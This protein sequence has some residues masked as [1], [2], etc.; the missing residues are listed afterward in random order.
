MSVESIA[1]ESYEEKS[2][3]DTY[4]NRI[5]KI[6]LI[7]AATE[8]EFAKDIEAGFYAQ[9]LLEQEEVDTTRDLDDL[10]TLCREGDEAKKRLVEA[11]LRL[12]IPIAHR[13]RGR[14]VP[15]M[16]L[17]QEGSLALLDAAQKFD[18]A[19]GFKFSTFAV[20]KIYE[21]IIL[22]FFTQ[23]R[24]DAVNRKTGEQLSKLSNTK[25]RLQET[26]GRDATKQELAVEMKM[27]EEQVAKL[28]MINNYTVSLD[29]TVGEDDTETL[30]SMIEDGE[31]SGDPLNAL[32]MWSMQAD[33]NSVL[34]HLEGH[35][36][37]IIR[38]RYGFDDY[39]IV[40]HQALARALKLPYRVVKEL[41][42]EVLEELRVGENAEALREYLY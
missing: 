35:K 14:G 37:A 4:L 7:D 28:L 11:N 41:E 10:E 18:Y 31:D 8:V 9:G 36:A 30:G 5:G 19:K 29:M 6:A 33:V 26:L 32:M 21:R 15:L 22:S 3:V 34:S 24:A 20:H 40:S 38:G 25:R 42:A 23:G 27:S 2:A 39:K 16:D 1:V 17:I 13:Y 12:V